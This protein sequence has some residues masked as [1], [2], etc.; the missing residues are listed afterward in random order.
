M[1]IEDDEEDHTFKIVLIGESGVGKTSIISQFVDHTFNE[2]I[3]ASTGGAFSSITLSLSTGKELK[4]DIWDTAGEERYR[5]LTKLFYK[6]TNAA[7]LVYDITRKVSFEQ[8]KIYWINQIREISNPNIILVIAANKTDLI[9]DEKVDELSA[10]KFAEEIDAIFCLVSAK[11]SVG[12]DD[13]FFQIAKK[14]VGNDDIEI[15]KKDKNQVKI[16]ENEEDIPKKGKMKIT[17]QKSLDNSND[18]DND[19]KKCC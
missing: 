6:D 8:L 7:V 17:A 14:Y 3:Q 15:T 19:K 11:S 16:N 18:I 13:I 1:D 12:I 10:R 2:D 5:S 9:E 4:F